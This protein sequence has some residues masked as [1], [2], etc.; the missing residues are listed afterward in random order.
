MTR[1]AD[2][3]ALFFTSK[4]PEPQQKPDRP[5]YD[6]MGFVKIYWDELKNGSGLSWFHFEQKPRY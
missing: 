2:Y 3:A 4:I 1:I 5:H 6:L